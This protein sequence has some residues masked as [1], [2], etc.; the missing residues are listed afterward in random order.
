MVRNVL[1]S[2]VCRCVRC[3]RAG[4]VHLTYTFSFDLSFSP[5]FSSEPDQKFHISFQKGLNLNCYFFEFFPTF[6][7]LALRVFGNSPW[8]ELTEPHLNLIYSL[9]N[10]VQMVYPK[11]DKKK[12][13]EP[14]SKKLTLKPNHTISLKTS[15]VY[16]AFSNTKQQPHTQNSS[17]PNFPFSHH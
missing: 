3:F 2:S 13:Q 12:S 14:F 15:Q 5:P 1:S 6:N 17:N 11:K 9:P 8:R 4:R 10:H 7:C 16:P